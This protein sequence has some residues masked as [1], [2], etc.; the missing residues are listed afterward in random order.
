M[1]ASIS[2]T[3]YVRIEN[4]YKVVQ[5]MGETTLVTLTFIILLSIQIQV[6]DEKVV[7][8]NFKNLNQLNIKMISIFDIVQ[9]NLLNPKNFHL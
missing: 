6:D 8:L 3:L 7:I 5:S 9:K 2:N 4:R 1:N